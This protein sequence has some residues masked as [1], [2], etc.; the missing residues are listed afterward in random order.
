MISVMSTKKKKAI[1]KGNCYQQKNRK[2]SHWKHVAK[3]NINQLNVNQWIKQK[4]KQQSDKNNSTYFWVFL[5][6]T[7]VE[8]S[9]AHLFYFYIP[10]L[11]ETIFN[12]VLIV[13]W[14]RQL[15]EFFLYYIFTNFL[16]FH[17]MLFSTLFNT[18]IEIKDICILN[19]IY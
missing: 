18:W 13:Y 14:L 3:K 17:W 10:K 12:D 9:F 19:T 7:S 8:C 16:S 5:S 1:K 2:F 15:Y 6:D 11:T 4:D